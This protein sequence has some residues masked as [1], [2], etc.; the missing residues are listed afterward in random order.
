MFDVK[1]AWRVRCVAIR[2]GG[3]HQKSIQMGGAPYCR[4][5]GVRFFLAEVCLRA[6][7]RR[8]RLPKV[9]LTPRSQRA[10]CVWAG[11]ARP[12][13]SRVAA[14][15]YGCVR[16]SRGRRGCSAHVQQGGEVTVSG[17][18]SHTS[19]TCRC[20]VCCQTSGWPVYCQTR[21]PRPRAIPHTHLLQSVCGRRKPG[22]D[23][24]CA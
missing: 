12:H 8:G 5:V 6:S 10:R 1:R 9:W 11:G 23:S 7:R 13:T 3:C 24:Q 15:L 19:Q 4:H 2:R 14:S 16:P 17:H 22:P 21:E 18:Q 20:C